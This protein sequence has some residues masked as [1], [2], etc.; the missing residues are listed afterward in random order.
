M[1]DNNFYN[2][3]KNK[4]KSLVCSF[5]GKEIKPDEG[6]RY[7]KGLTGAICED[8]AMKIKKFMEYEESYKDNIPELIKKIKE[9]KIDDDNNI[10]DEKSF[11]ENGMTPKKMI[12][13]LD[14]YVIGQ[15]YAKKVLSTAIYNH[16]LRITS[17][18]D[19]NDDVEL[20]KSNVFL[21]GP[22]G[23]GKT[24]MAKCLAKMLNVP[25]AIADANSLTQAGYVGDDVET[26]I[27]RLL[28]NCDYDVA[29]AEHG[30]IFIDE[31]DKIG[32]KSANPSITRDVSGEGVQQALLKIVE[33]SDVMVPP[34]GGRK[35]P[36]QPNIK[37]NT[38]NILFI[39]AGAFEGIENIVKDRTNHKAIGYASLLNTKE[40]SE[41]ELLESISQEDLLHFGLIPELIGRFPIITYV[42]ALD[43][44]AL[45]KILTEPK[46]AL[47]KQY[48]K[49][50]KMS[51]IELT[52]TDDALDVIVEQAMKT[53]TGARG[54]RSIC[55]KVMLD[56]MCNA[57]SDK[58]KT[59]K[60]TIDKQYV[61]DKLGLDEEKM[62]SIE[63]A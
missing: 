37:V 55:E 14:Q 53:K 26:I 62:E 7:F 3:I 23:A 31:I 63:A 34:N 56:L 30:I 42:N 35:H 46:N 25:F 50:L 41:N 5:C 20:E 33:G 32:R 29:K 57:P 10:D 51:G 15:D 43:K 16:Y 22:S 1:T 9:G 59:D 4:N 49:L 6:H 47:I 36:Q 19:N 28:Q 17:N 13:Y 18:N 27:T 60:V 39:A 8:C 24:L 48:E 11:I 58:D 61:I 40:K 12:D 52:F 44:E 45:K 38:K 21:L 54:L 2:Q